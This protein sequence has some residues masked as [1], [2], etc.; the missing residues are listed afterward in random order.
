MLI[1]IELSHP[2][3]VCVFLFALS[4]NTVSF[5]NLDQGSE[6]IIFDSI[7]TTFEVSSIFEAAGTVSKIGSSLNLNPQI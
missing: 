4:F 2:V 1:R 6:I 7:L 3:Y 5:M